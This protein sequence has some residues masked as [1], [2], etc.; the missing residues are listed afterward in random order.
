MSKILCNIWVLVF[1]FSLHTSRLSAEVRY[2]QSKKADVKAEPVMTSENLLSLFA[3]DSV[4]LEKVKGRWAKIRYGEISGWVNHFLLGKNP[5]VSFKSLLNH[6]NNNLVKSVRRRSSAISS[7]G[8]ARG[9]SEIESESEDR[10]L[11]I[12]DLEE[13]ETID[14][15]DEDVVRFLNER[16][17]D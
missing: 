15:N 10:A 13:M 11:N 16:S 7:A 3:G 14:I 1:L 2:V 8:A 17:Q 4:D 5:P 12:E 9:L 6:E